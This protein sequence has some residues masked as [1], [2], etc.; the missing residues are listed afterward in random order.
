M[1]AA[2]EA[3]DDLSAEPYGWLRYQLGWARED[4]TPAELATGKGVRPL[5]CLTACE[6]VG[7]D[8]SAAVPAAAAVELTHEFSLIHDDIEDGDTVR[9]GRAALWHL[10]GLPQGLNAG[11]LLFI[12]ARRQIA[13]SPVEDAVARRMVDRYDVACQRLA[14]GQYLDLAFER[15]PRVPPEHYLEM[16]ARKTG[17]LM[18]CAAA[19]GSIAG[20][21]SAAAVTGLES[22]GL[23][24]GVAFQIQDDVLGIW[25]DPALTGKPACSDLIRRKKSLPVLMA[26][27]DQHLA[28]ALEALYGAP[29]ATPRQA[30][31][32]AAAMERRGLRQAVT[33]AARE[34]ASRARASL[35]G[36]GLARGP[37]T[38]L[39]SLV[40]SVVARDR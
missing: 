39:D 18:S 24:L 17:A 10:V 16:V 6:A 2:L 33:L 27:A 23:E 15:R 30:A 13:G 14:E 34:R 7:S 36:L 5:L 35:V 25:G 40:E 21:G 12:V 37:A 8:P 32:V 38:E 4:G 9:R 3:P 26:L 1:R 31:E 19:L 28:S 29:D 22:Y 11:D 20:G